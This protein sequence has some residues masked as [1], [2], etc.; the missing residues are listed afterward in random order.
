[1]DDFAFQRGRRYGAILVDLERRQ[2]VDLLPDREAATFVAW[3]KAHPGV[4][5]I[6]RDRGGAYTD[7]ARQA[8]PHA[9]QVADR[10]H[11]LQNLSSGLD[12]LLT[13][14]Q[15]MLAPIA[16][17]MDSPLPVPLLEPPAAGAALTELVGVE[18]DVAPPTTRQERAHLAAEARR[19]A[20]YAQ[21]MQA[22]VEGH[23]LNTIARMV[24]LTRNTVRRSVCSPTAPVSAP[25]DG[26]VM[27]ATPSQRT[28]DN[29]GQ[30]ANT[31]A[32]CC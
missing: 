24:G 12:A 16:Q 10:F 23:P 4:E 8:A 31:I 1:M 11:L 2:V 14:E 29:V 17:Q 25:D 32:Q 13:R 27:P 30:T 18:A 6:S 15:R 22:H 20:R 28:Y 7:G 19:Q 21:V 3:L 5:I 9:Q 26:G